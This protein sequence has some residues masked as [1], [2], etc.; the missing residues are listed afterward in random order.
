[1]KV[2]KYLKI[3]STWHNKIK[4]VRGT[5][6]TSNSLASRKMVIIWGEFN[7]FNK[8]ENHV[9]GHLKL[10]GE[11]FETGCSH[12]ISNSSREYRYETKQQ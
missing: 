9:Y 10:F 3:E 7:L 2:E 5:M 6:W 11:A 8:K 1:M 4:V 12:S